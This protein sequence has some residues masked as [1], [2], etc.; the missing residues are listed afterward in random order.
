MRIRVQQGSCLTGKTV[1]ADGITF[2]VCYAD[3]GTPLVVIEQV[4]RDVVQVTRSGEKEFGLI[5]ARLRARE[6]VGA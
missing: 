3:D 2:V 6:E 5:L 1:D 4:G